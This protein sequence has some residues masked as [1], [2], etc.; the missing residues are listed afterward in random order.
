[1]QN[2]MKLLSTESNFRDCEENLTTCESA[3]NKQLQA[4]ITLEILQTLVARYWSKLRSGFIKFSSQVLII[5]P[6]DFAKRSVIYVQNCLVCNQNYHCN[7]ICV[8]S[9]DHTYHTWCLVVHCNSSF[10]C[11]VKGCEQEFESDW[12][13]SFGFFDKA[14]DDVDSPMQSESALS[15]RV[16]NNYINFASFIAILAHIL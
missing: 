1:M 16:S 8:A 9:C 6:S 14:K 2:E 7:D 15:I 10:K 5:M 3:Y 12:W 4:Q 11:K 13:L